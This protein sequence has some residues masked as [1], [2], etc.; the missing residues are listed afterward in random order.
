[1]KLLIILALT[2]NSAFV[3]ADPIDS[4]SYDFNVTA[5]QKTRALCD[6]VNNDFDTRSWLSPGGI[7]VGGLLK[8]A[9]S[10]V[11]TGFI[12]WRPESFRITPETHALINSDGYRDAL[13]ACFGTNEMKRKAFTSSILAL[14]FVGHLIGVSVWMLPISFVV[15]VFRNSTWAVA[16]PGLMNGLGRIFKITNR[17]GIAA[18]VAVLGYQ[19]LETYDQHSQSHERLAELTENIVDSSKQQSEDSYVILQ[20]LLDET[21]KR[22]KE[23]KPGDAE[24]KTLQKRKAILEDR[25]KDHRIAQDN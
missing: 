1:M 2:L 18:V 3:F 19:T 15:R 24:E 5:F 21:N 6:D 10:G 14:D 16:N 20:N 9:G 22:L 23:V 13:Y 17:A 7:D 8:F 11:K 4:S 25:L 12:F